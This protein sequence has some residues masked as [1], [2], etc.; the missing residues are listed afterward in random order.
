MEQKQNS[1]Q[2]NI[3]RWTGLRMIPLK[4][5]YKEYIDRPKLTEQRKPDLLVYSSSG[6]NKKKL[7]YSTKSNDAKVSIAIS[8]N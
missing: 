3:L 5:P 6:T 7:L 1:F 4:T 8:L 2:L